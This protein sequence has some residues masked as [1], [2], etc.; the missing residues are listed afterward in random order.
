MTGL[1]NQL[2]ALDVQSWQDKPK[3]EVHQAIENRRKRAVSKFE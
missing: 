3:S 2:E 1:T